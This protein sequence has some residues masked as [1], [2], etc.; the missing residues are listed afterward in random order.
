LRNA[1]GPGVRFYACGEYGEL[2]RRPHYH[3]ILFGVAF[4]DKVLLRKSKSGQSLYTSAE[5]SSYW[6]AGLHSIGDV[7]FESAAYVARYILK[8]VTGPNA[9]QHYDVQ[10]GDG[11]VHRRLPEFTIMSRGSKALGTGGIGFG[12][13]QKYGRH[14]Y[15]H[16]SVIM[17]GREV[18][19]PKY[20]D[21]K[22]EL[23]Y[24][25][26]YEQVKRERKRVAALQFKENLVDR[27][28][29]RERVVQLNLKQMKR[30]L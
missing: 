15:E 22:F 24:P 6:D 26:D 1:R 25:A 13:Y 29:V 10:D 9:D 11:V 17:R 23:G 27:R 28:R 19:P 12:W 8:K 3:A 4:A 30:D 20:Y 7:S 18:K 14:A 2:N 5:L 21:G 16:D